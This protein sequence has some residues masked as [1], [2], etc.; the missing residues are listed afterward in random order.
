LKE[1]TSGRGKD[2]EAVFVHYCM[3]GNAEERGN[4]KKKEEKD[5]KVI[6]C[7]LS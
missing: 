6:C 2:V 3:K 4:S 5:K 1:L 7:A